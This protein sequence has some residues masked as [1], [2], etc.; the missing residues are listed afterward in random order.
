MAVGGWCDRGFPALRGADASNT[1]LAVRAVR[2][3][4]AGL[5][6]RAGPAGV[7]GLAF[8]TRLLRCSLI[9]LL[10]RDTMVLPVH[11]AARKAKQGQW[12]EGVARE[13]QGAVWRGTCTMIRMS[14]ML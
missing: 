5:V 3:V 13:V 7:R 6:A 4:R 10:P 9:F 12:D 1:H 8:G 2:A 11:A 14:K